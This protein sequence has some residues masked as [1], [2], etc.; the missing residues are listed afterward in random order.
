[1]FMNKQAMA[2]E[3]V[4][5]MGKIIQKLTLDNVEEIEDVLLSY[6]RF[7][8]ILNGLKGTD[9]FESCLEDVPENAPSEE[10]TKPKSKNR[11]EL[12]RQ[13]KGGY[14]EE[15]DLYVPEHIIRK[16]GLEDGDFISAVHLGNDKYHFEL[17]EKVAEQRPTNRVQLNY[18]ILSKRD[19]MLVASEYLDKDGEIKL[20]KYNDVPHT[21]LIN[22][23]A[24]IKED[25]EVGSI[26]DI[27]YYSNNID[28][29]KVIWK[30]NTEGSPH[31]PPLPSSNYKIKNPKS[32]TKETNELKG[33]KVLLL[34]GEGRTAEFEKAIV[35]IGGELIHA[36][37]NEDTKRLESMIKSCD[38]LI[39][40]KLNI[41]HPAAEKAKEF[42][43]KY[44]KPFRLMESR[45][46]SSLVQTAKSLCVEA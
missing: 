30:H 32:D 26:V 16:L 11:Y 20:I 10:E 19:S 18:C 31:V 7:F 37:G 36:Y 1:M 29:F 41:N 43:K 6:F 9:D 25:L 33:K 28:V 46:I 40:M 4:S 15:I 44:K 3:A 22:N 23:E 38:M 34:G 39:T 12:K 8:K 45:G 42:A 14:L 35:S 2:Q 13:L 5:E 21:F 24:R 17:V 27:A